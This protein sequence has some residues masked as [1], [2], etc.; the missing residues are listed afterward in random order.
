MESPSPYGIG[1]HG[2]GPIDDAQLNLSIYI[3]VLSFIIL[4]F[5]S[6][7]SSR[8]LLSM[9]FIASTMEKLRSSRGV[10]LART[11]HSCCML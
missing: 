3:Y 2:D 10:R 7:I 11:A 8:Y 4:I 1:I 6:T 5:Q 9:M